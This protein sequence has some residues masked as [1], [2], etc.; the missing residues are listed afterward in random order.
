MS[1][2]KKT[3]LQSIKFQK[4]SIPVFSEVL[5]R[6]PWV[7]YGENNLLP[8]DLISDN[9]RSRKSGKYQNQRM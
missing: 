1:E 2:I 8:P 3:E 5:Q 4:A 7:Y 9:L 6:S